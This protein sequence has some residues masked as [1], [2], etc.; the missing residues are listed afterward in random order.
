[1]PVFM[2]PGRREGQEPTAG[3]PGVAHRVSGDVDVWLGSSGRP[4]SVVRQF[5]F[6]DDRYEGRRLFS[7]VFGT[8]FLVLVAAGGGMVNA[9]FGGHAIPAA[10]LVVAPARMLMAIIL[11]MEPSS[12]AHLTLAASLAF[13]L[14]G[15]FPG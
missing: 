5:D 3:S 7:E 14:R 12:G 9:R 4:N 11:F 2:W 1:M 15:T 13:A 10:S 6:F 8:F